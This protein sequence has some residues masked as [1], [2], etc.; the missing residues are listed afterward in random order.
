[1]RLLDQ[2]RH[3]IRKKHYSIRTEQAYTDWIK[4]FIL[5]HGKRHPKDMGESEIS[6]YISY[7]AVKRNVAAST[8]NQALNAIVFLYK[9]VLKRDLGDFGNMERAKRPKR[10]PTVLTKNEADRVLT[11][12]SG[13]SALMAKLL[14]G[15][16][17]RLMECLR[18]RVK[19]I[20]FDSNQI[21][22][23]DGKG[24][25][26]RVTM[27][28][29]QLKTQL[30]EYLKRVQIIHEKDLKC[31]FGEVYLPYALS[32]KYPNAAKEWY[33]QYVFPSTKISK[34]PRSG[35]RRRHHAYET[36]LQRAVRN[37]ARSVGIPKPVSPHTFRHCFATHLLEAGYDIRTVQ[38]LLGHKDVSTTMIYTHVLNK[39]GMGVKSPLDMK[40]SSDLPLVT[41]RQ[42]L[43]HETY[44]YTK[45]HEGQ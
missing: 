33:W 34:D 27:L 44:V 21:I 28:P 17:L 15:C 36:A 11:V 18:L 25:K 4:R 35:K 8:Q 3:V 37:A 24:Q 42:I 43:A 45:Q 19:D 29:E 26:D 13:K 20:E 12:M 39:G 32:R 22:V 6:K 38:D 5:F 16:G 23:R 14:Y 30:I 31:G 10:L 41:N 7:L 40:G 2:V 1:M 9:Q